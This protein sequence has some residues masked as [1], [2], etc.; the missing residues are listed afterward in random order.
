MEAW[1]AATAK[2]AQAARAKARERRIALD[3]HRAERDARVEATAAA[4]FTAI[5]ARQAAHGEV[6]LAEKSIAD[7]LATLLSD[8][9]SAE[10]AAELC[11]LTPADVR[12]LVRQHKSPR[13]HTAA[14][15]T[16]VHSDGAVHR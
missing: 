4:V 2:L 8:G 11:E 12:R 14:S 5:A 13:A 7:G 16:S 1:M 15:P 9:L 10:Q 3:K 6:H